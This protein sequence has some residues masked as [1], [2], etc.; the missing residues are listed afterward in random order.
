MSHSNKWSI[1][2]SPAARRQIGELP[3]KVAA[4]CLAFIA[5]PLRERPTL[6]GKPLRWE[7]E[8]SYSARRGMW[9]I[10]YSLDEKQRVV[11]ITRIGHR[12]H[13]YD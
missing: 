11:L 3:E 8:G 12:S 9:R 2:L 4:A 7:L 13:I 6:V 5:G 1:A 10:I